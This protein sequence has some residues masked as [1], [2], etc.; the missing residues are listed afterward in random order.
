MSNRRGHVSRRSKTAHHQ[1]GTV[2]SRVVSQ[3]LGFKLG[4]TKETKSA[5]APNP[6]I[7][8]EFRSTFQARR[9]R[10]RRKKSSAAK[11]G[12]RTSGRTRNSNCTGCGRKRKT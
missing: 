4:S 9:K 7:A 12:H 10:T 2:V 5:A 3:K 8:R 6:K 1:T 11:N